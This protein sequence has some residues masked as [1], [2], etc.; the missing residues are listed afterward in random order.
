MVTPDADLI[1]LLQRAGSHEQ[2]R[3]LERAA[4]LPR[5]ELTTTIAT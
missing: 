5:G 2:R 3:L 1:T 4:S